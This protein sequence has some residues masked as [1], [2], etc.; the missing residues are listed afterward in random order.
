MQKNR[1]PIIIGSLYKPPDGNNRKFTD[2]VVEITEKARSES[3]EIILGI[4]HNM[5]LIKSAEHKPTQ[6]FLDSLV[7]RDILPT[8]T[9]PTCIT[10]NT[11][12]LIDN[13]FVSKKL[14]TDFE[15]AI[16]IHD[17]SD[18]MPLLTLLKQTKVTEKTNL[19]FKS[20]NLSDKKLESIRNKLYSVDWI[21]RLSASTRNE[22]FEEF[23][24]IVNEVMD[25]ISPLKGITI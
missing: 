4:D 5:D 20:R 22:N 23:H 3:K 24:K 12:T 17:M 18:H 9:H 2:M 7:E 1:K 8:I 14:H 21:G 19:V 15:S 10:H 25:E 6:H 13:I 16:I 11:A